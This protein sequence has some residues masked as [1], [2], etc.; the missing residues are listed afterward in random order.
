MPFQWAKR[1]EKRWKGWPKNATSCHDNAKCCHATA[2]RHNL[3]ES[4]FP[5][6]AEWSVCLPLCLPAG[7][8]AW[9]GTGIPGGMPDC[10]LAY[11]ADGCR[12]D[13]E[14]DV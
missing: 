4:H 5:L 1:Q 11:R 7:T 3:G 12:P 14:T 13:Q 10:L 6:Q 9:M 2:K 8:Q